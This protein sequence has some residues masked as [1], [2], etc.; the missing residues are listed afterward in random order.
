[1]NIAIVTGAS[2]GIGREFA[3]RIAQRYDIDEIWLIARREEKLRATAAQMKTVSRIFSLDLTKEESLDFLRK[4]LTE[5]APSVKVLVN[6]AGFG[7][8]GSVESQNEKDVIDMIN[9]NARATACI[10]KM[11]IPFMQSGSAIINVSSVSGFVPLPYLNVYSATKAFILRFSQALAKEL[12]EKRISVTAVCPYWVATE[13]MSVAQDSPDGDSINNFRLVTYP[14][15]VVNKA[16][17]DVNRGKIV[18][19]C[20][21]LPVLIR[22]ACAVLPFELKMKIWG[23]SRRINNSQC[24]QRYPV[25][26]PLQESSDHLQK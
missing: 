22:T 2:S 4:K 17:K 26:L 24:N 12:E 16:M 11:C 9:L 21:M 8:F 3:L 15:T 13:M 1:M 6:S 7:K 5:T 25:Q 18:S 19:L 14:Y 23:K 10:S 20:G